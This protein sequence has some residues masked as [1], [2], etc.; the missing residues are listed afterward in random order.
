MKESVITQTG[1]VYSETAANRADFSATF[2]TTDDAADKAQAK[3]IERTRGLQQA[4]SKLGKDAVRVT[5]SFSM[6]TL[7][8]EYKD[9]DGN[10]IEDQRADKINGYQVSLNI[11]LEV[12]DMSVLEN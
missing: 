6:R 12:R 5:T 11:S 7:Y 9:K 10:R 2:L 4:L 8:Q 1:Y 3:A